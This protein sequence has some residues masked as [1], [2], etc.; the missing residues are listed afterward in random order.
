VTPLYLKLAVPAV[1]L[2][3]GVIISRRI[4]WR[5]H[6]AFIAYLASEF[7]V[8]L[9]ILADYNLVLAFTLLRIVVRT[10]V[11]FE[12]LAFAR[13]QISREARGRAVG[14]SLAAS[15]FAAGCPQGLILGEKTALFNQY[16]HLVLC[17]ALLV[18]VILRWAVPI[19]GHKAKRIYQ[20]ALVPLRECRRHTVYRLGIAAWLLVVAAA[21]C[22]VR[23]G[24]GYRLLPYNRSTWAAVDLATYSAL[25]LVVGAMTLAMWLTLPRRRAAARTGDAWV[26]R[27]VVVE[28]RKTA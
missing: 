23:G 2:A 9:L 3:G 28:L 16:Y 14:L 4:S 6:P 11:V 24:L 27:D 18:V 10:A 8:R 7:L 17:A 26:Q 5:A 19:S 25:L 20:L 22:F 13:I 1:Q 15:A 12:V 21:G